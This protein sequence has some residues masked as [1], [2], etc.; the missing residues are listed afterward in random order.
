MLIPLSPSIVVLSLRRVAYGQ[1][2]ACAQ[3]LCAS[4]IAVAM[5]SV[6]GATAH[7]LEQRGR[8]ESVRAGKRGCNTQKVLAPLSVNRRASRSDAVLF[9]L[10][11]CFSSLYRSVVYFLD[12]RERN[13]QFEGTVPARSE[14]VLTLGWTTSRSA[15]RNSHKRQAGQRSTRS[16]SSM[17]WRF[18]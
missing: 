14:Q 15:S 8:E 16:A 5:G 12:V 6:P 17:H 10:M 13:E 9:F 18:G 7:A 1:A 11:S 3:A 4:P 2:G